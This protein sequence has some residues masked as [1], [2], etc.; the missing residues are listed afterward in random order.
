M[1]AILFFLAAASMAPLAQAEEKAVFALTIE[2]HAF[3]PSEIKVPAGQPFKIMVEN[4]DRTPEEFESAEL[5]REKI[6]PGNGKGTVAFG[7]LKPGTYHFVG[8]FNAKT[9]QGTIVVE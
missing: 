9:A 1:R 6:I 7:P 3:T 5:K 2:N 8:E 4:K